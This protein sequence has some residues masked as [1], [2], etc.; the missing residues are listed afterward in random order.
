MHADLAGSAIVGAGAWDTPRAD[1]LVRRAPLG[2]RARA[3]PRGASRSSPPTGVVADTDLPPDALSRVDNHGRRPEVLAARAGRRAVVLRDS[4]TLHRDLLTYAATRVRGPAGSGWCASPC[5]PPSPR[6]PTRPRSA[7]WPLA[8]AARAA[9]GR[10][11]AAAL[12][13]ALPSRPLQALDPHGPGDD[14]RPHR[15]HPRPA[16]RRGGRPRRGARRPRRQPRHVAA[17]PGDPTRPA[18]GHAGGHDRGRAGDRRHGHHRAGQPRAAGGLRRRR[19]GPGAHP[20]RGP[21]ERRPARD[22]RSRPPG[23]TGGPCR[24][25]CPSTGVRPAARGGPRGAHRRPARRRRGGALRR[26]RA[27]APG[28]GPA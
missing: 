11:D 24:G 23:P 12:A 1:G 6:P 21:A 22:A 9:P 10:R 17:Q 3:P 26:D 13:R 4:D 25:R 8:G 20:H 16:R 19:R 5:R 27:A 15:A 28:D 2:A 14:P 7:S 18:R